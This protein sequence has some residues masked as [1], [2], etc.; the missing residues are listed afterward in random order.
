MQV[1]SLA[2]FLLCTPSR[3]PHFLY[4]W[5]SKQSRYCRT[6]SRICTGYTLEQPSRASKRSCCLK[7]AEAHPV[8]CS[9]GQHCDCSQWCYVRKIQWLV[10][11]FD[12]FS[13]VP[14]STLRFLLLLLRLA[15]A[16]YRVAATTLR[17]RSAA[18]HLVHHILEHVLTNPAAADSGRVQR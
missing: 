4:G 10:F 1:C 12:R 13:S 9:S 8:V 2:L 15:R 5:A 18:L 6:L 17:A 3:A 16:L 14:R 7:S 11:P